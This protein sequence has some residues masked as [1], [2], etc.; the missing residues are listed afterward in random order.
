MHGDEV[1]VF[2]LF[3]FILD[4]ILFFRVFMVMIFSSLWH[5]MDIEGIK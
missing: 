5:L 2:I 4:F 1:E 3:I